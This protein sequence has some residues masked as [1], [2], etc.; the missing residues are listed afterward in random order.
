MRFLHTSDWHLGRGLHGLSMHEAQVAVMDQIVEIA[1]TEKVDAVLIAGDVYDR[2]YPPVASVELLNRTITRLADIAPVILTPGNHDSATRL[3][4]CADLYRDTLHVRSRVEELAQP[5]LLNDGHG[6]VAVYALPYLDPDDARWRLGGD[7]ARSHEAV[8]SAA[9]DLVRADRATR[10]NPRAVVVAHAFVVGSPGSAV[11][12]DSERDLTIGTVDCVGSHVFEG[13]DYVALGHLHGRQNP[14]RR[15][16]YSGS[17]L[18]YSF[19]EATHTKSVTIV[20]LAADGSVELRYVDLVQPREMARVRGA[21][22]EVLDAV[23][24][25]DKWVQVTVTDPV[26]PVDMVSRVRAEFAHCLA[27]T[28]E[29]HGLRALD[30]AGINTAAL[31]PLEVLIEFITEMGGAPPSEQ[32]RAALQPILAGVF[33]QE[34]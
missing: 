4:F 2:A 20:D 28:H 6:Q 9:L 5:V 21:L 26:R 11:T 30:P 17:P 18:R 33:G 13:I 19:S 8:T 27:I 16:H 14:A 22:A 10:G 7:L 15:V 3:G 29:P 34:Q 24:H 32:E 31:S 23:E 25:R 1:R 12:S